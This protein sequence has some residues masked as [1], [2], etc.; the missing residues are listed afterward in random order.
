MASATQQKWEG[1][2]DQLVGRVKKAWG[3]VTDDDLTKAKGDYQRLVGV[4]KEKTGKTQEE[5]EKELDR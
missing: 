2:W 5:I 3:D 1:R 4:L